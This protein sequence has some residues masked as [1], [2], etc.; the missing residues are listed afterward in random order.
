[1]YYRQEV[2]CFKKKQEQKDKM[3]WKPEHHIPIH[4]TLIIYW[5][6]GQQYEIFMYEQQPTSYKSHMKNKVRDENTN[7]S[8]SRRQRFGI[9]VKTAIYKAKV[10]LVLETKQC[11]HYTE[12]NQSFRSQT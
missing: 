5:V 1:M 6:Q 4:M 2:L 9:V 11:F 7:A 12:K 10:F 8:D 3:S